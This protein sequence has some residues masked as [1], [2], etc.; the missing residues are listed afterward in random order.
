MKKKNLCFGIPWTLGKHFLPPDGCGTV[1][2]AKSGWDA[3]R[4]G[5]QLVRVLMNI[6]DEAR[7]W[8]ILFNF[9]SDG[10]VT[11]SECCRGGNQDQCRPQALR[12]SVQLTDLLSVLLRW[13]GFTRIQKAVVGQASRRP[14]NSAQ[15][16]FWGKSGLGSALQLFLSPATELV[17][18]SCVKSTFHRA[19]LS[20]RIEKWLVFVCSQLIRHP[21]IELFQLSSLFQVPNHHRKVDT[22]FFGNFLCSCRAVASLTLSV[23]CVS[24]RWPPTGL[25]VFMA[26]VSFARLPDPPLCCLLAVLGP[27]VSL[28]LRVVSAAYNPF[29]N[30]MRIIWFYFLS[31]ILLAIS[32]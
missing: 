25:L 2:P 26:L 31:D 32:H 18:A 20:N 9:W 10:C 23:G 4:S 28:M 14:P 15:E 5:S 13:N 1:F 3:W 8:A 6:L 12:F 24:L 30:W 19:S 27:S 7:L 16:L 29:W 22:E 17:V 11:C 21:L